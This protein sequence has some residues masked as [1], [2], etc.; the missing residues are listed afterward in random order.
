M[1][2]DRVPEVMKTSRLVLRRSR[3]EDAPAIFQ[4]YA[5]DPD[6]TRYLAW[7]PHE[8]IERTYAFLKRCET[9]WQTGEAFPWS[10]V[11]EK[12]GLV[13]MVDLRLSEHRAEIGYVLAR[14][15]WNHGYMTEAAQAVV[16]WALRQT[17]IH[18]VWAVCD[19]ENAGSARVLEKVGMQRE[20]IL[21]RWIIHPNV[22]DEPRDCFC[23]AVVKYR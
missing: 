21:R 13:G 23:Y 20:G 3:P 12:E 18:R 5:Q 17:E 22:S 11:L 2:A 9:V 10:I 4:R 8:T 14:S 19:V 16:D 7:K 6:V 15:Y 1:N